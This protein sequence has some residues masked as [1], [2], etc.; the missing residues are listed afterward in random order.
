MSLF[1]FVKAPDINQGV[2]EYRAS[3]GALLLDVRSAQEYR[4]GHIPGSVNLPLREINRIEELADSKA[5]PLFLYCLSGARS[6]QATAMLQ[7][8]GYEEV[9]N[10]GGILDYKGKVEL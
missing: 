10:I 4:E 5:D 9:H 2:N 7:E 3:P 6:R 8:M 1:D